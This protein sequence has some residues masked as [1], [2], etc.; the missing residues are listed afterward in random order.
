MV[1]TVEFDYYT[2]GQYL[3]SQP[4]QTGQFSLALTVV[5]VYNSVV[6][7]VAEHCLDICLQANV[8]LH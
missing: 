7:T 3:Q 4:T 2:H 1:W 8:E 6:D 5:G